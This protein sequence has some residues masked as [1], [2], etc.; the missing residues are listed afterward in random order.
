MAVVST[1]DLEVEDMGEGEAEEEEEAATR[2]EDLHMTIRNVEIR[3]R[4][5]WEREVETRTLSAS[6]VETPAI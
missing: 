4:E 6:F 2:V 5:K 3:K 1:R